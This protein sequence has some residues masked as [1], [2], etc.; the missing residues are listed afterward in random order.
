MVFIDDANTRVNICVIVKALMSGWRIGNKCKCKHKSKYK[1][2]NR[3]YYYSTYR[4]LEC[5][6]THQK[7]VQIW[8]VFTLSRSPR[9]K[10]HFQIKTYIL[11]NRDHVAYIYIKQ[12]IQWKSCVKWL[13]VFTNEFLSIFFYWMYSSPGIVMYFTREFISQ[14][15]SVTIFGWIFTNTMLY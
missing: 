14:I 4:I 6:N 11:K 12:F 2:N 8:H 3:N 10:K 15:R 9:Q 7:R 1:N 13:R 5:K